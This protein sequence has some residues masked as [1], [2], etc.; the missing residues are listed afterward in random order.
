MIEVFQNYEK[1]KN[2]RTL[3]KE[4]LN[5]VKDVFVHALGK[6]SSC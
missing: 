4:I 6:K 5:N 2:I 3:R 1:D